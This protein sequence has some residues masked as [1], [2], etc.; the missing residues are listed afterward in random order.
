MKT[1]ERNDNRQRVNESIANTNESLADIYRYMVSNMTGL[2]LPDLDKYC[3]GWTDKV[4]EKRDFNDATPILT[5][6]LMGIS[7]YIKLATAL[8]EIESCPDSLAEELIR[9]GTVMNRLMFGVLGRECIDFPM[10]MEKVVTKERKKSTEN[11]RG[12]KHAESRA[13]HEAIITIYNL[14]KEKDPKISKN[15]ASLQI[16]QVGKINL[17]PQVIRRHLTKA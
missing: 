16:G 13:A 3:N 15:A 6:C 1:K 12:I 10:S 2:N 4:E 8:L 7:Q 17:T 5:T 11:A 14:L 9:M